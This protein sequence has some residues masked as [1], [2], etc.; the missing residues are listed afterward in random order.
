MK[1]IKLSI[2]AFILAFGFQAAKAQVSI[3]VSIGAPP[4]S[5][6]VVVREPVYRDVYY[7]RPVVYERPSY[8]R[9]IVAPAPR[10]AYYSR[11][12]YHRQ[13][14]VVYRGH[15]DRGQHRGRY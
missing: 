12:Y 5:R 10:R 9:V 6:V 1:T 3:G 2:A 15:S 14:V 11:S 4:P 8:Q 13:P 7:E